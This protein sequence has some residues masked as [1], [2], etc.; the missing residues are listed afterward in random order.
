MTAYS[1][2]KDCCPA[3]KPAACPEVGPASQDPQPDVL[4]DPSAG[5]LAVNAISGVACVGAWEEAAPDRFERADFD[6]V[7]AGLPEARATAIGL[8]TAVMIAVAEELWLTDE[9]FPQPTAIPTMR[10]APVMMRVASRPPRFNR[11][12]TPLAAS[13]GAEKETSERNGGRLGI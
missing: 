13:L 9:G 2:G 4:V 8:G 12:L 5:Q 3:A 11:M 7:G 6:V 1:A 10:E